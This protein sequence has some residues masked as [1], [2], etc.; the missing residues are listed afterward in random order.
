LTPR[1]TAR[2]LAR[3]MREA[4]EASAAPPCVV[5]GNHDGVHRGHR[6]LLDAARAFAQPRGLRVVALTFDPHPLRLLAPE[7]APAS[8]TSMTRRVKLLREA[9]CDD[10][11]VARFDAA[12]AAQSP[13]RFVDDVL[14][15]DLAARGVVLGPDFRFGAKRAGDR[16]LLEELGRARDLTVVPVAPLCDEGG[17]ISSSRIRALLREGDVTQAAALLGRVH[18]VEGVVVR[19]DQRGRTLGFPT[20]NMRP[21]DVLLPADGVYAVVARRLDVPDAPCL[22]GVANLGVRP[23][24]GAGRSVEVHLF[25]W[26]GDLY[27]APLRVGFVARLREERRF[28][29]LDALVAQIRHDAD[30]ARARVQG[31]EQEYGRWL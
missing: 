7:R 25:D 18:D 5:P 8:L 22:G 20:A 28:A 4:R 6:A 10:V 12:F 23:T 16:A 24:V 17:A 14:V 31:R 15:R 27:D 21:E 29:G 1:E 30:D 13:E 3:A 26:H 9:G 11:H 19:G 2:I